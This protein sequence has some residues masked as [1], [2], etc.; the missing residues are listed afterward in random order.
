MLPPTCVAH[1]CSA[2]LRQLGRGQEYHEFAMIQYPLPQ[3]YRL[4]AWPPPPGLH[5][6]AFFC[7][8]IGQRTLSPLPV[9]KLP[10]PPLYLKNSLFVLTDRAAG[11]YVRR[12]PC[13]SSVSSRVRSGSV[14]E[15]CGQYLYLDVVPLILDSV[16]FL[17][18]PQCILPA[19]FVVSPT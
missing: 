3:P 13:A 14:H 15:M 19:R 1:A 10:A 8:K 5:S 6:F 2:I 17:V 11:P 18:L 9:H 7:P 4:M 16:H 12:A